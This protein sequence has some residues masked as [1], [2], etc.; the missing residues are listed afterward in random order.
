MNTDIFFDDQSTPVP[1]N[2]INDMFNEMELT[3]TLNPMSSKLGKINNS[4]E[5]NV[6]LNV[7]LSQNALYKRRMKRKK[8]HIENSKKCSSNDSSKK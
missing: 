4:N 2:T 3:P 7:D 6:F 1:S 5:S 8:L